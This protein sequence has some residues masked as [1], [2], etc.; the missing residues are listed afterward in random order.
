MSGYS[1]GAIGDIMPGD[2]AGFLAKPFTA[3]ML[4]EQVARIL[5]G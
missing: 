3:T 1:N 4:L 5:A 2:Q